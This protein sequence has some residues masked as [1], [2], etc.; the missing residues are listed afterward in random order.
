MQLLCI[1]LPVQPGK[2]Q[3]LK[4]FVKTI[5]ESKWREYEDF[6][7]RSC[8]QKVMW[9]LQ[10]SPQGDQLLIYNEAEDFLKLSKE[11]SLSTHH[12]DIWFGRKLK[13]ITGID[14]STFD[15]SRLPDLLLKYGY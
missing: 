9:C 1:A 3:A 2:S 11:F 13:E 7:T 15:P 10:R 4:D 5:T 14:F 8:V 6:Q 12:F